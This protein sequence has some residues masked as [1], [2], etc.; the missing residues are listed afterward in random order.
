MRNA[1][2]Y[3]I[4][5]TAPAVKRRLPHYLEQYQQGRSILQ[6]AKEDA[7]FSPYLFARYIV[8]EITTLKG[9]KKVLS[10]AMRDPEGILGDIQVIAE[11]FR[12]TERSGSGLHQ[13]D[14]NRQVS[15]VVA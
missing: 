13:D 2:V 4:K 7:N 12:A 9:R 10:E 5:K 8:E 15:L 1:S 3:H 14:Q 11:E 6:M